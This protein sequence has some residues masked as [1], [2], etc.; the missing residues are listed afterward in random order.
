MVNTPTPAPHEPEWLHRHEHEPNPEPPPGGAAFAVQLA[1]QPARLFTV[2]TLRSLPFTT[3]HDCYIVSTGHGTS[4]PFSFGGVRL[5]DLLA[6]V[7]PAGATWEYADVISSDGFGTRLT[8]A[9]LAAAPAERPPLLAYTID[10][11]PLTR[12]AGLVRLV[13]PTETDDALKQVK[14]IARIE[15]RLAA[16]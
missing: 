9:E 15:I 16:A 3:I 8:P 12:Q 13:V 7:L 10:G 6:A 11:A 1:E 5:S 2:A 14:W 4:G